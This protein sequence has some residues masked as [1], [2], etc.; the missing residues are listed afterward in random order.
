MG[1]GMPRKAGDQRKDLGGGAMEEAGRVW[2]GGRENQVR[3]R[4]TYRDSHN[5]RYL[6]ACLC[7]SLTVCK[8]LAL[9]IVNL[10]AATG[11]SE[12]ARP[13]WKCPGEDKGDPIA[14]GAS[15]VGD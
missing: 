14:N 15:H 1:R 7:D 10:L 13:C 8:G 6:H 3:R 4:H 11:T 2:P 12:I 5:G 9:C